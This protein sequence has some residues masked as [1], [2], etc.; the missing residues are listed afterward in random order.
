MKQRF[1]CFVVL[2]LSFNLLIFAR[3]LQ[4]PVKA[5]ENN[6]IV[7]EMFIGDPVVIVNGKKMPPLKQTPFVYKGSTMVCIDFFAFFKFSTFSNSD[8]NSYSITSHSI[9]LK[10]KIGTEIAYNN[11]KQVILSKTP[12]Y[13]KQIYSVPLKS[14]MEVFGAT[15]EWDQQQKKIIISYSLPNTDLKNKVDDGIYWS[16]PNPSNPYIPI[17][18]EID[19]NQKIKVDMYEGNKFYRINGVRQP[20]L[21]Q[22][23]L[24][25][26]SS[27]LVPIEVFPIIFK[28]QSS[29]QADGKLITFVSKGKTIQWQ[30]YSKKVLIK[31]KIVE[32]DMPASIRNGSIYLPLPFMIYHLGGAMTWD[33]GN[34]KAAILYDFSPYTE[35]PD[36]KPILSV[37]QTILDFS[38]QIPGSQPILSFKISNLN[39][40]K[41][42]G[43]LASSASWIKLSKTTFNDQL[44][45]INVILDISNLKTNLYKEYI[46]IK[47][48]GGDFTLP[49]RLDLVDKKTILEMQVSQ[50][51]AR[52]DGKEVTLPVA[53]FIE[54]SSFFIP[55]RFT[56]ETFG[57]KIEWKANPNGKPGGILTIKY[58][59]ITAILE[60]NKTNLVVNG[61]VKTI[62]QPVML[63]NGFLICP[64]DAIVAIFNTLVEFDGEK[65]ILRLTF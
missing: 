1:T 15:F 35:D 8:T 33:P 39:D 37:S 57:S 26:S 30:L 49:V 52:V 3:N 14:T 42:K 61:S 20:A 55:V 56:A 17:P 64:I 13:S 18:G 21:Q 65:Q 29:Y 47:S 46:Y 62:K 12:I 5:L 2:L 48:N 9:I 23:P 36:I 25:S 54:K 6:Q 4:Q 44:K 31:K 51:K 38:R 63:K 60:T 11:D 22:A 19:P 58:K 34:K 10:T 27:L 59:D 16:S 7:V 24:F 32:S 53:P 43:I 41:L 40:G 28:V 50:L 45:E